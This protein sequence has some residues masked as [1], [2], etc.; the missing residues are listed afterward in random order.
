M[1][2]AAV[3]QHGSVRAI[4]R[5]AAKCA[6][7]LQ[8]EKAAHQNGV[9][10]LSRSAADRVFKPSANAVEIALRDRGGCALRDNGGERSLQA[11]DAFGCDGKVG[12]PPLVR[13]RPGQDCGIDIGA[14]QFE[15]IIGERH[16][17]CGIGV[18]EAAC[19]IEAVSGKRAGELRGD[20]FAHWSDTFA[21]R[22]SGVRVPLAAPSTH[23]FQVAREVPE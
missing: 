5:E 6:P 8:H 4:N 1:F 11:N 9:R 12:A 23:K 13:G 18:K 21:M 10:A 17:V 20:D 2:R 3:P 15:R 14:E 16:A 22:R 7:H 19:R